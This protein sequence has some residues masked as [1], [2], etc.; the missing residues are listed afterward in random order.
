MKLEKCLCCESKVE[1]ILDWGVMPLANN[2]NVKDKYPLRLNMCTEC[3]HLQLDETVDPE[4]MFKEYPY[5]SGTS[6][7]SKDFFNDFANDAIRYAPNAITVLDIAC[8]DGTQLD[9]FKTLGL[10]TFGIDP[11]ENLAPISKAKGHTIYCGMFPN[12]ELNKQ[13]FDIITAQNVVAH[14]PN[15][16]EFL[17]G[18]KEKMHDTSILMIA[19]SQANM[20]IGTEFDTIYHEHISYFNTLSMQK[21]CENAGLV[22]EDVY[23]HSIHGTSYIFVIR[24]VATKNPVSTRIDKE[25]KCGLYEDCTYNKWVEDCYAKAADKRAEIESYKENGYTI[26]GCGAAAK[27]ITFLNMSKTKVDFLVDTTP[28]KWYSE[29]CDTMIYP[30]EYL[31]TLKDEKVLFVILAWNFAT[32]IT[33]NIKKFRNNPKDIFISTNEKGINFSCK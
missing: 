8:N 20:I 1:P 17:K 27:G 21:L 10:E 14:V 25:F 5:F 29:T 28:A 9:S 6:Q 32:E 16:L 11:A 15:P 7:T 3:H 24:K 31:K 4:I 23:T 19:T 13:S 26:V 2:Y 22:L 33:N 30:F 18:C 12:K